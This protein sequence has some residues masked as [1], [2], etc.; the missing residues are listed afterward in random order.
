MFELGWG[1]SLVRSPDRLEGW[2]SHKRRKFILS[3]MNSLRAKFSVLKRFY[4]IFCTV[5]E[6]IA[7]PR[8]TKSNLDFST[9]LTRAVPSL[10][11]N[12]VVFLTV[13]SYFL[14]N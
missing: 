2:Q 1:Q 12:L 13:N 6:F 9:R 4:Q 5:T 3:F 10:K 7:D 11:H 8:T 14:E